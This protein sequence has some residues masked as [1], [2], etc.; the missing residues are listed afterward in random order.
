MNSRERIAAALAGQP[1][2]RTPVILHN[3]LHAAR[4]AG[5]T[6]A[7]YRSDPEACATAHRKSLDDFGHD[8]VLVDLD[9]ATLAGACGAQIDLPEDLP[10]RVLTPRFHQP[11]EVLGL[12]PPVIDDHPRVRAW[13]AAV[14]AVVRSCGDRAWVRGNGDQGPFS[15]AAE[16]CESAA[17]LEASV[18][19]DR[20]EAVNALLSWCATASL[21]FL[22]LLAETGCD[23]LSNG[24]SSSG[25]SLI[26]PR[27]Y[28]RLA[29]P[30]QRRLADHTRALGKPWTLHVCGN[31]G[32]II[33]DLAG[34]GATALELD[35]RTDLAKVAA[36]CA[37]KVAV[38][39]TVDPSG[40]MTLGTAEGVTRAALAVRAAFA[41]NTRLILGPGCAIP[42]EAPDANVQALVAAAQI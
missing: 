2:D 26:S 8:A 7:A 30:W 9:T 22:E 34:V 28:R 21:R 11:E 12:A 23:G 38:C 18:D 17:F 10:G 14:R 27:L 6:Q 5:I 4:R 13:L 37:G 16:V 42:A 36:A 41:G 3:F 29:L 19:P 1:V 31:A 20:Q 40:V 15:L 33:D 25:P 39:G 24:D 35:Y 32:P